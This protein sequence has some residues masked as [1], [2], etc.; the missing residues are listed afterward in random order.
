M[1]RRLKAMEGKMRANIHLIR[2]LEGE[3]RENGK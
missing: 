1:K 2:I 3:N